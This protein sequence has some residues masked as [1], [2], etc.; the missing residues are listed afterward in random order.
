MNDVIVRLISM[1]LSVRAFTV[2]DAQGDY[3]VYLNEAL[4]DEQLKKSFVHEKEHIKR[5]DF[6]KDMTAK[7]IESAVGGKRKA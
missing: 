7:A 4:S 6:Y 1:P 3:N 5:G 2:P